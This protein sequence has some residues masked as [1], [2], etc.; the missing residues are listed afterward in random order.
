MAP[1]NSTQRATTTTKR[2]TAA[3]KAAQTRA[4]KQAGEARAELAPDALKR[5]VDRVQEYAGRA[6]LVQLGA[7]LAAYDAVSGLRR[8]QVEA[9]LK[10]LEERGSV[11][12]TRIASQAELVGARVEHL[13][14]SGLTAGQKAA[15]EVQQRL[16]SLT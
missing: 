16:A 7:G 8:E 12:R 4:A 3:K 6:M 2:S 13:V 10:R 11:A 9:E 1:T 5:P 15:T 14:Q